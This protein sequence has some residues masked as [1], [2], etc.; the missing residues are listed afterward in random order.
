MGLA[1]GIIKAEGGGKSSPI[2]KEYIRLLLLSA[3]S[4][5]IVEISNML[6]ST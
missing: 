5:L 2:I 1:T 3:R 4:G 6:K